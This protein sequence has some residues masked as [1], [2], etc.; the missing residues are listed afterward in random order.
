MASLVALDHPWGAAG[1][2]AAASTELTPQA[3]SRRRDMIAKLLPSVKALTE[4]L[5]EVLLE[6]GLAGHEYAQLHSLQVWLGQLMAEQGTPRGRQAPR[7]RK[8]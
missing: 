6:G 1:E 7:T 2:G 3:A 8:K 5:H 4:R